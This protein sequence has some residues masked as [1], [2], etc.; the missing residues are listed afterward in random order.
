M[1]PII[2]PLDSIKSK[3]VLPALHCNKNTFWVVLV[4]KIRTRTLSANLY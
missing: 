4:P 2:Q 1:P 3:T